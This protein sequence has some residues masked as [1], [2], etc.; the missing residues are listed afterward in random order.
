MIFVTILGIVFRLANYVLTATQAIAMTQIRQ[1]LDESCKRGFKAEVPFGYEALLTDGQR[2]RLDECR[3]L[4]WELQFIR[5]SLANCP[6]VI[7]RDTQG[8]QSWRICDD[9]TLEAFAGNRG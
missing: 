1:N 3:Q 6:T 8:R 5:R 2:Q 7:V 9:G 4:G